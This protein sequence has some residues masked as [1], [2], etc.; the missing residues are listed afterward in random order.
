MSPSKTIFLIPQKPF[1]DD[2]KSSLFHLKSYFCTQDVWILAWFNGLIRNNKVNFKIYDFTTSLTNYCNTHIDQYLTKQRQTD[3]KT[4]LVSYNNR[5]IFLQKPCRNLGRET[6]SRPFFVFKK[7]FYEVK[8][9]GLQLSF[10][11]FR[12]PS[13]WDTIKSNC[14]KV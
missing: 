2:E 5:N 8:A 6:S 10:S 3:N 7:S 13:T 14:K 12:Q 4:W 11:I 1:K 9:S